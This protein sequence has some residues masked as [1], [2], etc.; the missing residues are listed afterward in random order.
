MFY[1]KATLAEGVEI[2]ID[3]TD[4]NVY[5]RCPVCGKEMN[6]DI[7]EYARGTEFDLCGT[8]VYCSKECYEQ[9]KGEN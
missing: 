8:S 1:V 9:V 5:T 7:V 6:V 4:E 3:I 2:N